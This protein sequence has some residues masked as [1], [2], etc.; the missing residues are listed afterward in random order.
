MQ[1]ASQF[2]S[3]SYTAAR[4]DWPGIYD[5]PLTERN[6]GG[7]RPYPTSV[8]KGKARATDHFR[9]PHPPFTGDTSE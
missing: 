7:Q 1:L 9:L 2:P 3:T 4:N 5:Q 8:G 6:F